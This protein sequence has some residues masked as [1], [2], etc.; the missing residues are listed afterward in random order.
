MREDI[1]SSQPEMRSTICTF[2]SELKESIQH[3][4]KDVIQSIR[5]ELEKNYLKSKTVSQDSTDKQ[6]RGEIQPECGRLS[7]KWSDTEPEDKSPVYV[8]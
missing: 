2:R 1:K 3:E 5:S 8:L 6:L 4:M 7:K